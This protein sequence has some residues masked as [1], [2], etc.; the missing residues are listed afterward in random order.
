MKL[1]LSN[2][3]STEELGILDGCQIHNPIGT[4]QEA[5]HAIK[6]KKFSSLF[7]KKYLSEAFNKVSWLYMWLILIHL[8]LHTH[9]ISWTEECYSMVAFVVLINGLVSSFFTPLNL[10]SGNF[11]GWR[12][13]KVGSKPLDIRI[14]SEFWISSSTP[15]SS[16]R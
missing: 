3:L 12:W 7:L 6:T 5:L 15:A 8:R 4:A 1:I 10:R 9:L 2:H 14:H 11:R 16:S 13:A